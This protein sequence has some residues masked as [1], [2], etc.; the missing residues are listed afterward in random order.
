M[1]TLPNDDARF[2]RLVD[3]ELSESERRELLTALDREPEGWRRCAL[4]FLEAQSWREGLGGLFRASQTA[5]APAP[6]SPGTR[7]RSLRILESTLLAV[8]VCLLLIFGLNE[9]RRSGDRGGAAPAGVGSQYAHVPP[10]PSPPV[11]PASGTSSLPWQMV[12]LPASGSGGGTMVIPAAQ[13]DRWDDQWINNL[14]SAMPNRV[15]QAFERTGHRV[16]QQR[17][18]IPVRMNDGRILFVPVEQME[19]QPAERSV[20]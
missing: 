18:L 17:G 16:Q 13:R 12:G 2:D 6:R 3:G 14:P 5:A 19:I 7:K 8:A 4:A 9:Y 11:S 15:K 1:N 10:N 20:Y